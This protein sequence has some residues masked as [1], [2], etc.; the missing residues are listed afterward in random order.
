M[1]KYNIAN[2]NLLSCDN[3]LKRVVEEKINQFY[4]LISQYENAILQGFGSSQLQD[5][6]R[7]QVEEKYQSIRIA[8]SG[9]NGCL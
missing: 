8:I 4:A 3:N 9:F 1:I 2:H 7:N 5:S 6:I